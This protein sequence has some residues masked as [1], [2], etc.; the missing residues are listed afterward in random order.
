M[1]NHNFDVDITIPSSK[2]KVKINKDFIEVNNKK[3]L[4]DSI[5]AIKYGVSLVGNKKKP[6]NKNYSIEIKSTDG[7]N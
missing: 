7:S 1:N 2:Q 6:S 3:I 4:C 5:E